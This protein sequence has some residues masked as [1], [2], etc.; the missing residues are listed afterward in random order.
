MRSPRPRLAPHALCVLCA[1]RHA[2]RDQNTTTAVIVKDAVYLLRCSRCLLFPSLAWRP[3]AVSLLFLAPALRLHTNYPWYFGWV[4]G[5]EVRSSC[6]P[7]ELSPQPETD[8]YKHAGLQVSCYSLDS[9]A[10][11]ILYTATL[12]LLVYP[13]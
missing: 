9:L 4:L 3:A 10:L 13:F 11:L 2:H 12:C 7:T 5:L 1:D 8:I 6:L